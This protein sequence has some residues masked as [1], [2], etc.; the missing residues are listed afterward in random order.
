MPRR[1]TARESSLAENRNQDEED[2]EIDGQEG[3]VGSVA[4]GTNN[5]ADRD[6][7]E[8]DDGGDYGHAERA[9]LQAFLAR[10]VMTREEVG[11]VLRRIW[12]VK[13]GK[14]SE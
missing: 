7:D 12:R 5:G 4:V 6:E 3:N 13:A 14:N 11:S 8:D 2:E 9:F 10:S 1:N